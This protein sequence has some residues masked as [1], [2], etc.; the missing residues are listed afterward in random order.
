MMH[1]RTEEEEGNER[2]KEREGIGKHSPV[3]LL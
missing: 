1:S 3:E 2:K